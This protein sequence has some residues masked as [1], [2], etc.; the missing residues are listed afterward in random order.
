MP[1]FEIETPAGSFEVEAPDEAT[2]LKAVQQ[3]A[4]PRRG[5][6]APES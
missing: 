3:F 1:V 4:T 6:N 5:H 2:A